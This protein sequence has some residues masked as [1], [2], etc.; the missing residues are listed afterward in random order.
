MDNEIK[1][2]TDLTFND[3]RK[4]FDVLLGKGYSVQEVLNF[5]ICVGNNHAR[6]FIEVTERDGQFKVMLLIEK[7]LS[8]SEH[9]G[10][11]FIE[12]G[13]DNKG[14]SLGMFIVETFD[15]IRNLLNQN[16]KTL[17]GRIMDALKNILK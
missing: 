11:C 13:V 6:H 7:I 9:D 1:N 12:T 5:P 17:T 10:H 14:E 4:M 2:V 3:A 8:I 15:E 16:N